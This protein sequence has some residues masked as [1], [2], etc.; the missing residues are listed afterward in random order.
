M[1][2]RASSYDPKVTRASFSTFKMV[3]SS[4]DGMF[5]KRLTETLSKAASSSRSSGKMN[6]TQLTCGTTMIQQSTMLETKETFVNSK[7]RHNNKDGSQL[8]V[9]LEHDDERFAP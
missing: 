6:M 9:I 1:S 4:K 5:N 2:R 8:E 3:L 7:E